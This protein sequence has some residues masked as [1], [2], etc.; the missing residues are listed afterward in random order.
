MMTSTIELSTVKILSPVVL[1]CSYTHPHSILP[2][3][4]GMGS[5]RPAAQKMFPAP[6]CTLPPTTGTAR[7]PFAQKI[8]PEQEEQVDDRIEEPNRCAE[9]VVEL[10][11]PFRYTKVDIV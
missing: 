6:V 8:C 4:A 9:T 11:R 10:L 2:K 3:C 5:Q 7:R 1:S